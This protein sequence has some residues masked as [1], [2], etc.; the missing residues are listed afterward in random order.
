M[1]TTSLTP[2]NSGPRLDEM[3]NKTFESLHYN[4]DQPCASYLKTDKEK[5]LK[6]GLAMCEQAAILASEE[7]LAENARKKRK[8]QHKVDSDVTMTDSSPSDMAKTIR[9]EVENALEKV[10]PKNMKQI[11]VAKPREGPKLKTQSHKVKKTIEKKE[12]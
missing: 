10:L 6:Y 9:E 1:Y 8:L 5:T 4:P 2:N 11:T 12:S 3:V 7:Q